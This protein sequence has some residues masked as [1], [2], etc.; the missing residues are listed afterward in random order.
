VA[1]ESLL[2]FF[3]QKQMPY[4]YFLYFFGCGLI[5]TL[6][7]QFV[8]L[9]QIKKRGLRFLIVTALAFIMAGSMATLSAVGIYDTVEL[10]HAG[11][12]IGFGELCPVVHNSLAPGN[13][14]SAVNGT[15]SHYEHPLVMGVA[16]PPRLLGGKSDGAKPS[17]SGAFAVVGN[18]HSS[19][20][21]RFSGD[22]A[23]VDGGDADDATMVSSADLT[24]A[25]DR[26]NFQLTMGIF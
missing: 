7:G 18:R 1:F 12:S 19:G 8:F 20:A 2:Q 23:V 13:N 3:V 6:I 21:N 25:L 5:A 10:L 16:A 26:Q 9:A 17:L 4:D 11:G 22:A 14:S 15:H 24:A